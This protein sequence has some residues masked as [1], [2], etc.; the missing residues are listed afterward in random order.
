MNLES[1]QIST[2]GDIIKLN[3]SNSV[4]A[5]VIDNTTGDE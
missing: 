2:E 4:H 1:D 5:T 3:Q